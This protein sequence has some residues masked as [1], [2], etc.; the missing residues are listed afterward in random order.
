MAF[1]ELRQYKIYPG[2]MEDWVSLMENTII[3]FQVS[4][5]MVITGSFRDESDDT[6]YFW[7]RRFENDEQC[8]ALYKAVYESETWLNDIGPKIPE[9]MDR[10]AMQI[11]RITP[12]PKSVVQ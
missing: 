1:Y 10:S 11:R 2:K 6:A 12:T 7:T 3:P 4:Q 8:K 9:L 5:G